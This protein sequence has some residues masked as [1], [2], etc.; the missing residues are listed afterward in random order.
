MKTVFNRSKLTGFADGGEG[1]G[2]LVKDEY[3]T[4]EKEAKLMQVLQRKSMSVY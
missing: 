1:S 2:Q 3:L 4:K